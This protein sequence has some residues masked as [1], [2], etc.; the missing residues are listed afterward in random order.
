[1]MEETA[2][3]KSCS[4]LKITSTVGE[5]KA[6]CRGP[7]V[8]ESVGCSFKLGDQGEPP[9]ESEQLKRVRELS[10]KTSGGKAFPAEGTTKAE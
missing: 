5:N 2:V 6:E 4:M 1:M 10:L 7:G 8:P 9:E 3:R